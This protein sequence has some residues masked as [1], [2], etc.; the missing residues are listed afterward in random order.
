MGWWWLGRRRVDWAAACTAPGRRPR[1]LRA[2][3]AGV[4]DGGGDVA[5]LP[6]RVLP[7]TGN[8][9]GVMPSAVTLDGSSPMLHAVGFG[10]QPPAERGT[11]NDGLTPVPVPRGVN[12]DG[13]SS[14]MAPPVACAVGQMAAEVADRVIEGGG[15][16]LCPS[17]R[18]PSAGF[19]VIAVGTEAGTGAGLTAARSQ[20]ETLP[21]PIVRTIS[22]GTTPA[23]GGGLVWATGVN[24]VSGHEGR[25]E[26][27]TMA[28]G[29]GGGGGGT[30][31]GHANAVSSALVACE[32]PAWWAPDPATNPPSG[33]RDK[34]EAGPAAAQLEK[35]T[36][37]Q[38]VTVGVYVT[39]S[40]L[41]S[42]PGFGGVE[43]A[44]PRSRLEY[45]AEVGLLSNKQSKLSH[46]ESGNAT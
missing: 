29:G 24:L 28:A 36:A 41:H 44:N 37:A 17:A 26:M 7:L 1:R 20:I 16:V 30:A 45:L 10:L 21:A 4:A 46:D 42:H 39:P 25:G 8:L 43:G 3:V 34:D 12:A 23:R 38:P 33:H 13:S 19:W 22:P 9:D 40:G 31:R 14:G 32:V 18:A 35:L 27:C 5:V 11:E 2:A 15:A 6:L